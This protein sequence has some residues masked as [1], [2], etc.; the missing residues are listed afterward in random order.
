[1]NTTVYPWEI[2]PEE[3][4]TRKMPHYGNIEKE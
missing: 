1:L 4:K 2:N 3:F